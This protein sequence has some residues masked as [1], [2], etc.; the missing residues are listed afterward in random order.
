MISSML[1]SKLIGFSGSSGMCEAP[2]GSSFLGVPFGALG[3]SSTFL[4][5]TA[6]DY[7]S[8]GALI[9]DAYQGAERQ[10]FMRG[11]DAEVIVACAGSRDA[12]FVVDARD[13]A[14][15]RRSRNGRRYRGQ[16][17]HGEL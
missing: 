17:G 14:L 1:Q 15:L 12:P 3:I 7:L 4:N 2:F 11:G 13:P 5:A 9:A 6:H 8:A 16:D 10:A